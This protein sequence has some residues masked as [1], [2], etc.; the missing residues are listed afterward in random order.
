MPDF[1]Q[2]IS[3]I[4]MMKKATVGVQNLYPQVDK[5]YADGVKYFEK[6]S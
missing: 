3:K 6:V 5:H 2:K 1:F 4:M